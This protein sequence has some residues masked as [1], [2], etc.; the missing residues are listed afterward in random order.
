MQF[1][2]DALCIVM[3]VGVISLECPRRGSSTQRLKDATS[4]FGGAPACCATTQK[5]AKEEAAIRIGVTC[6]LRR[7]RHPKRAAGVLIRGDY[8][9][10]N[11]MTA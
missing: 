6:Q 8:A 5:H 10:T 2:N 3:L 11:R 9:S 4:N 7:D 1:P